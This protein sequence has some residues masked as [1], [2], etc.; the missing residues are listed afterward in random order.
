MIELEERLF[1]FVNNMSGQI[2]ALDGFMTTMSEPYTWILVGTIMSV[3]A[4]RT[5]N[6]LLLITIIG[7]LVSLAVADLLSFEVIKP[8]FARERPCWMLVHVNMVLGKCGGSYGFTS[9]HAANAFAVW[10]VAARSFG[11]R[12]PASVVVLTLATIVGI[13]RVYLGLHFVGDVL[14]G[15]ILGVV[16]AAALMSLGLM[17]ACEWAASKV[18]KR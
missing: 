18:F 12:S 9:N 3:F 4:F 6:S 14:G 17:P 11:V 5:K 1:R 13:S 7:S 15:A 8:L 10:F 16:T 2:P